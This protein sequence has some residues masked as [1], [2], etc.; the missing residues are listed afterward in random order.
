[1]AASAVGSATAHAPAVLVCGGGIVGAATA[2]AI[3]HLNRNYLTQHPITALMV[4]KAPAPTFNN[5]SKVK[6]KIRTVSLSRASGEI[7]DILNVWNAIENKHAYY[8]MAIRHEASNSPSQRPNSFFLSSLL[9][10][11]S[12]APTLE[13]ADLSKPMGFIAYNDEIHS[14]LHSSIDAT[15]STPGSATSHSS[16]FVSAISDADVTRVVIPPSTDDAGVLAA[17]DVVFNKEGGRVA[18]GLAE[19]VVGCEGRDS[20]LRGLIGSQTIERNYEQHGFVVSVEIENIDDGNVC[21]FQNFFLDGSIVGFLPTGPTTANIVYSQPSRNIKALLAS[22]SEDIV[23]HLNA[24][25]NQFAPNDIPLITGIVGDGTA[26]A[27][28][29]FPLKLSVATTPYAPRALLIGDAAHG[30]HPMAGQGL[31]MGLYDVAALTDVLLKARQQGVDVGSA[32][33]VG[34]PVSTAMLQH[35]APM[36]TAME[37]IKVANVAMPMASVFGMKVLDS[38]SPVKTL[39]MN[40]ASGDYLRSIR[41]ENSVL[42][43]KK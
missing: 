37:A 39:V 11:P 34:V 20:Q 25:L 18:K 21:C 6:G 2:C 17:F 19:L 29:A 38:L 36:I 30:V 15:P 5:A 24:K 31:N 9:G 28:G 13:F 40:V 14:A 16:S 22:P 41:G 12:T 26:R 27:M 7:L 23:S 33:S 3:Q 1:M 8:R 35:T 43:K 42:L 10:A 4:D 32:T